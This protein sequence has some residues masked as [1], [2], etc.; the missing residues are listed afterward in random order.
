MSASAIQQLNA[1]I[2][3]LRDRF[4]EINI[5]RWQRPD[6]GAIGKS[7]H[8]GWPMPYRFLAMDREIELH[9]IAEA[10]TNLYRTRSV[11]HAEKINEGRA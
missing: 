9:H 4:R 10:L 7:P 1:E 2:D 11:L 6:E 5:T 3:R 8:I